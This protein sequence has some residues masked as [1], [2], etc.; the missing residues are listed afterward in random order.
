MINKVFALKRQLIVLARF[1]RIQVVVTGGQW[2]VSDMRLID[3]ASL[4][5]TLDCIEE[6]FT[7]V[8]CLN[9]F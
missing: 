7:F 8:G 5:Y 6:Q 3:I 4:Q 1:K 9:V 2:S